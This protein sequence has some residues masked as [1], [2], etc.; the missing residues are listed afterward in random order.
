MA[1]ILKTYLNDY[2][3]LLPDDYKATSYYP[4]LCE[5]YYKIVIKHR[6]KMK[7]SL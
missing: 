7:S 1:D 2:L 5:L 4:R 3:L 6:G